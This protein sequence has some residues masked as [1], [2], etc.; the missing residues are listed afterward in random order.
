[1]M[2]PLLEKHLGRSLSASEVADY[3]ELDPVTVRKNYSKLGGIR[4]G[5]VYKF[6]EK[7]LINAVLEQNQEDLG[8]SSSVQWT[9]DTE[10]VA[11]KT[12]GQEMG[13]GK[14][15]GTEITRRTDRDDPHRLFA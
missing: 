11:H 9:K 2:H 5:R 6:F 8:R 7:R 12:A 14:N 1:M 10:T 4:V 15:K 13:T 3:L